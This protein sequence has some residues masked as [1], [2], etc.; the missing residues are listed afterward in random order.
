MSES[1]GSIDSAWQTIVSENVVHEYGDEKSKENHRCYVGSHNAFKLRIPVHS[2]KIQDRQQCDVEE[3]FH[4]ESRQS[5][6]VKV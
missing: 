2:M 4:E 5:F 1:P 6:P 3:H